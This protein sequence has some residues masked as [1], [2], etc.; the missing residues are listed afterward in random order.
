M[1]N[2]IKY[3]KKLTFIFVFGAAGDNRTTEHSCN[4]EGR[5]AFDLQGC[6]RTEQPNS[7]ANVQ[8]ATGIQEQPSRL[9]NSNLEGYV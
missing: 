1:E 5:F 6:R 9:K 2:Q 4:L 8:E 7:A 3:F